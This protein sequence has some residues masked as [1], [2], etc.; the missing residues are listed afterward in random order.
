M[1]GEIQQ[2]R[3]TTLL[4]SYGNP[5][6][7]IGNLFEND[8]EDIWRSERRQRVLDK[9]NSVGCYKRHC[10]HNSRGHHYNRLFHQLRRCVPLDA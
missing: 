5:D 1:A 6:Y 4:D 7:T 8:L 10:P 3:C 9:I 2:R